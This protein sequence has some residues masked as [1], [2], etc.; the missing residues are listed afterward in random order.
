MISLNKVLIILTVMCAAAAG[1]D[2][3][4]IPGWEPSSETMHYTADNLWEYINGAA[5]QFIDYDM[6]DLKVQEFK[7]DSMAISI[8][9]YDMGEPM[10]AFGIY[11]IESRNIE[12]RLAIGTEA[13]TTPPSQALM[14]KGKYY[15]K[16]YAFE[17]E[18]THTKGEA[19]L[20]SI[21]QSL[22]GDNTLPRELTY[23]PSGNQIED[24]PGF[25]RKGYQGLAE[26]NNCLF[27]DYQPAEGEKFQYFITF[28]A[29]G[30]T[31]EQ[32]LEKLGPK[33]QN[34]KLDKYM[35]WFREIP[36]QGYI[37]I[38]MT[39]SAIFGAS[40]VHNMDALLNKLEIFAR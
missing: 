33:W 16:I 22:P 34:T 31:N 8:D 2:F 38:I 39:H 19:V 23:L 35:V 32:V 14:L 5:D 3:P 24:S 27:A 7:N 13:V 37:G 21:A 6:Q 20:R 28:P 30:E 26:L 9:I 40:G 12:P 15:I 25:T 18:L 1:D 29:E 4:N 11:T 17:G 36:Y 10:S